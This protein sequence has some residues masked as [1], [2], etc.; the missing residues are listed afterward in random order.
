MPLMTQNLRLTSGISDINIP[1]IKLNNHKR[2][3]GFFFIIVRLRGTRN[4]SNVTIARTTTNA[5][6]GKCRSP[7]GRP[8]FTERGSK[9]ARS[10]YP[11]CSH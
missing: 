8:T 10:K 9:I 3:N 1:G 11:V 6:E 2:G 5:S 4:L 7:K